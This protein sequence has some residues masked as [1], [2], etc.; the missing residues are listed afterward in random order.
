MRLR[1]PE[2]HDVPETS[3]VTFGSPLR[4]AAAAPLAGA[5]S[6]LGLVPVILVFAAPQEEQRPSE[7]PIIIIQ[8]KAQSK[9]PIAIPRFDGGG[10]PKGDESASLLYDV[11]RDDLVFS[12]YFKRA[13][14]EYLKMVSPFAGR[15]TDYKEWQGIGADAVMV[16]AAH[17]EGAELIFEGRVYDMSE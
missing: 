9:L 10:T 7:S 17:P 12:Y 2:L 11:V 14:D 13:P 1:S 8:G 5:A 3:P 6:V 16:G 15:K 4:R